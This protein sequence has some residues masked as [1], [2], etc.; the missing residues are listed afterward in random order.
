MD[1][2]P[3]QP[4]PRWVEILGKAGLAALPAAIVLG[5][6]LDAADPPEWVSRTVVVVYAALVVVAMLVSL[7]LV[8]RAEDNGGPSGS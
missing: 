1:K 7:W 6:L 5:L 2:T 3:P 8:V 4:R